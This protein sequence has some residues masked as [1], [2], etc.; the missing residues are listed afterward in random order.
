MFLS[1]LVGPHPSAY[2]ENLG[3]ISGDLGGGH[4]VVVGMPYMTGWIDCID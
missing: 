4:V 3:E 1:V 2:E